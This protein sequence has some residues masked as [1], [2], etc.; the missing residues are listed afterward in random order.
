VLRGSCNYGIL[1]YCRGNS[2]TFSNA[3]DNSCTEISLLQTGLPRNRPQAA[4][5]QFII[6]R[7]HIPSA[8]YDGHNFIRPLIFFAPPPRVRPGHVIGRFFSINNHLTENR[9]WEWTLLPSAGYAVLEN[10]TLWIFGWR[11]AYKDTPTRT[12]KIPVPGA[13][14]RLHLPDITHYYTTNPYIH[15]SNT[16]HSHT[17]H[18]YIGHVGFSYLLL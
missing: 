5:C 16:H 18:P 9:S 12:R 2:P 10:S 13:R 7:F 8:G 11:L 6:S 4:N 17:A 1:S 3:T 14:H 15:H